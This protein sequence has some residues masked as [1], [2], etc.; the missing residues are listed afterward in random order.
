VWGGQWLYFYEDG[1][2]AHRVSF[3]MNLSPHAGPPGTS[4]VTAEIAYSR[5]RALSSED[6][7]PRVVESLVRAGILVAEDTIRALNVE[8]VS[9][10][11]IV[12]ERDRAA[13]AGLVREWL[14]ARDIYTCGRYGEWEHLN[15]DQCIASGK[16]AAHAVNGR[17]AAGAGGH[18]D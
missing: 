17:M 4:A 12:Y 13:N 5:H 16:Q 8:L 15:M 14:Q 2:P 3:P 9:P 7:G 10:A 1:F 6:P 11:H 18:R